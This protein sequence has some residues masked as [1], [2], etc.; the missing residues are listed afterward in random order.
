[1][2]RIMNPFFLINGSSL[3]VR[4]SWGPSIL[5]IGVVTTASL[6]DSLQLKELWYWYS[7][8]CT[9]YTACIA[10]LPSPPPPLAMQWGDWQALGPIRLHCKLPEN[11]GPR[12]L[13]T[14]PDSQEPAGRAGCRSWINTVVQQQQSP[15]FVYGDLLVSS[16]DCAH[17]GRKGCHS[18]WGGVCQSVDLLVSDHDCAHSWGGVCQSGDLLFSDHD[19]AHCEG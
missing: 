19:C 18:G 3:T 17:W 10:Y 9:L 5:P 1:M 15:Q 4:C 7:M 16:H 14:P 12:C 6:G 2:G 8:K 11:I 13:I